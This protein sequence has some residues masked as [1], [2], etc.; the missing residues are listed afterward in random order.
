MNGP[1]QFPGSESSF[2]ERPKTSRGSWFL[3]LCA[4]AALVLSIGSAFWLEDPT[5]G[6]PMASSD[7]IESLVVKTAL[8]R[9]A[10]DTQPDGGVLGP[11]WI[12]ATGTEGDSRQLIDVCLEGTDVH[13]AAR[14]ARIEVDSNSDTLSLH[15]E[16]ALVVTLP[17]GTT[18][19]SVDRHATLLLG[20]IP[21]SIDIED[22]ISGDQSG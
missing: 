20:P 3:F 14:R 9:P 18:D 15:L 5:I 11:W 21:M 8:H 19:G 1:Y 17:T 7:D 22:A 12:H 16:Q 4:A 6:V 2:V 10:T 13:I